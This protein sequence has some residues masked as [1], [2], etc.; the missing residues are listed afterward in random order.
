MIFVNNYFRRAL[1]G[2]PF[3]GMTASGFGRENSPE[4]L[5]E[6]TQAKAVRVFGG[7]ADLPLWPAA[8]QVLG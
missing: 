2:A 8:E 5:L 3:G 6:F 4:S 1:L 7:D